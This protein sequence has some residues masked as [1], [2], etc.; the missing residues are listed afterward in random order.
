MITYKTKEEIKIIREGGKILAQI[1]SK[2]I[3]KVKPGVATGYLEDMACRLILEAGGRPAFKG[4]K[5]KYDRVAYPTALC[6]SINE[7]VVHAPAY[8]SRQLFE[9]DIIGID[10]GME[11]P[12]SGKRKEKGLYTDMAITA[13]VGKINEEAKKLISVTKESLRRG[14][15][16]IKPGK[17]LDDLGRT[18]QSYVENEGFSVVRDL[19]GHGVG[20]EVHEDPQVPNYLPRQ[21]DREVV[22]FKPGM[23]LA[24]EPMVNVGT[25]K[26]LS[27][28]DG[29]TIVTADGNLSAHFEH[30]IAVTEK[31]IEILT[32]L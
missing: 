11:Y 19:V 24:I 29:F 26:V 27:R 18:I 21:K 14:L 4:L 20:Y 13:G 8:P 10:V 15:T 5:S 1:L 3:S 16:Q 32:E 30:T 22:L 31:G 7:E 12:Y 23:V 9:G 6:T 2:I 28:P 25:Y 17:S